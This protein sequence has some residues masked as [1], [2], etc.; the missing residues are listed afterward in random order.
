MTGHNICDSLISVTVQL[1]NFL[2]I[3][4]RLSRSREWE[5]DSSYSLFQTEFCGR[6]W[7][8]YTLLNHS[9]SIFS[10]K[11]DPKVFTGNYWILSWFGMLSNLDELHH[12]ELNFMFPTFEMCFQHLQKILRPTIFCQP[13]LTVPQPCFTGLYEA[14]CHV[15]TEGYLR[16]VF[17]LTSRF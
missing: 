12:F 13:H 4:S 16:I 8:L 3:V 11:F 2:Q 15:S 17:L 9:L 10:L 1:S 14:G 7:S 5:F 6:Y